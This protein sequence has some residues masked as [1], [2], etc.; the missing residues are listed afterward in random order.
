M[1][2]SLIH[3]KFTTV[4]SLYNMILLGVYLFI[5][6]FLRVQWNDGV[7]E[8]DSLRSMFLNCKCDEIHVFSTRRTRFTTSVEMV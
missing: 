2:L 8:P 7:T 1:S 6:L 5:L 4:H 3:C